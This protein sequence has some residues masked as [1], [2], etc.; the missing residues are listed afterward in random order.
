M[1]YTLLLV[2]LLLIVYACRNRG[3]ASGEVNWP[4]NQS[5]QTLL[6][7]SLLATKSSI[8]REKVRLFLRAFKYE[9]RLEV[10]LRQEDK[11]GY[12]LLKTYAFCTFSGK[13]GPK[14]REG[15]FQ[16]PEGVYHIDRFNPKSR[17][18]LSLGLNYPNSS[19]RILGNAVAP[20]SDIFIHGGC[21]SVGCI[22]IRNHGIRELF[23]LAEQAKDNG[24]EKIPVHIFPYNFK[25]SPG[26][27]THQ[28]FSVHHTFWNDLKEIYQSFE[29]EKKLPLVTINSSGKYLVNQ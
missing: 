3:D 27:A 18:F 12:E 15:D 13:L 23:L 4:L 1:K 5:K 20:G 10:W 24:Q 19:D 6:I 17:F 22:P 2:T 21:A 7:D 9:K 8:K 29:Q 14:R 26:E 25:N 11:E 28:E 16:I